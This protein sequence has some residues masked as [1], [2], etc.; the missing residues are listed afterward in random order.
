MLLSY[1][2]S[3]NH[4]VRF[5]IELLSEQ[6]T[7]GWNYVKE[8]IPIYLSQYSEPVPFHIKPNTPFIYQKDH[9]PPIHLNV[10]RTILILRNPK[11]VIIRQFGINLFKLVD[12]EISDWPE[13]ELH[14]NFYFD[15]VEYYQNFKGPKL[16]LFYEDIL[17]NKMK[18]IQ[19]LYDF[20]NVIKPAKLHYV[21]DNVDKLFTLC[22]TGTYNSWLGSKSDL[23]FDFYWKKVLPD[24][25]E[26]F[27][28]ALRKHLENP[29]FHFI[30]QKY[31]LFP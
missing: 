22:L 3:G 11:E 20:L 23:S 15:L 14:F 31:N 24:S 30:G 17:T 21:L 27:M 5:F 26:K 10:E 19:T 6:P 7:K 2:G 18:F 16:L 1:S 28:T 12:G 13:L 4:A 8:D 29:N 9:F 25:Q